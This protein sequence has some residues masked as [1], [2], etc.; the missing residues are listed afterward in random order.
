MENLRELFAGIRS[1]APRGAKQPIGSDDDMAVID[2]SISS[3]GKLSATHPDAPGYYDLAQLVRENRID[4]VEMAFNTYEL[5]TTNLLHGVESP[6]MVDVL[7]KHGAD[8]NQVFSQSVDTQ[9]FFDKSWYGWRDLTPLQDAAGGGR[10]EIIQRLIDHGADM[11]EGSVDDGTHP[12]A[13]AT[14][15]IDDQQEAAVRTLLNAGAKVDGINIIATAVSEKASPETLVMLLEAGADPDEIQDGHQEALSCAAEEG[16]GETV[17]LLLDY[18]ANV[19]GASVNLE[20]QEADVYS[21]TPLQEAAVNGH[22]DIVDKLVMRGADPA[23]VN[24]LDSRGNHMI[25]LAYE[26]M[27]QAWW[28]PNT[29]KEKYGAAVSAMIDHG[30]DIDLALK[31]PIMKDIPRDKLD[32]RI[33]AFQEAQALRQT[34]AEVEQNQSPEVAEQPAPRRRARL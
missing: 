34:L 33:V 16:R 27:D 15:R 29:E 18:G 20:Q 4:D 14:H 24:A 26:R 6:E 1:N 12:L 9:D 19:N 17:D 10:V 25:A 22:M 7:V 32:P 13:M 31:S 2:P 23:G 30:A 21:F 11:N 3:S 8:V 28:K 5:K